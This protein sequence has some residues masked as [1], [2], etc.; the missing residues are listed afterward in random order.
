MPAS[1]EKGEEVGPSVCVIGSSN[2]TKRSYSMDLE[3]NA[4]IVTNNEGLKRRLGE[5]ERWL[6]E[7]TEVVGREDFGHEDRKVGV[8]TRVAMWIV[9]LVGGAL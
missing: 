3:A 8:K 7:H 4:L 5:E 9:R 6:K 2:Y 1:G